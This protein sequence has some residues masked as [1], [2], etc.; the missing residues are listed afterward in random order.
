LVSFLARFFDS[1]D[2]ESVSPERG[3]ISPHFQQRGGISRT[4][5]RSSDTKFCDEQA[6]Q[7]RI[8]RAI[9]PFFLTV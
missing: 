1:P 9:L 6:G 4:I 2:A 7:S 8:M 3:R 5:R